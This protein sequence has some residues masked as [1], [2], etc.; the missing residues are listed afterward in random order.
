[1]CHTY[2]RSNV[3]CTRTYSYHH[4]LASN[5]V[6]VFFNCWQNNRFITWHISTR[7]RRLSKEADRKFVRLHQ[8]G[9]LR[10]RGGRYD[11]IHIT[12]VWISIYTHA[13]CLYILNVFACEGNSQCE[14]CVILNTNWDLLCRTV[15]IVHI[16]YDIW[17]EIPSFPSFSLCCFAHITF[18]CE[19]HWSTQ[20]PSLCHI[21]PLTFLGQSQMTLYLAPAIRMSH[22]LGWQIGM[23]GGIQGGWQP[24]LTY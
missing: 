1:M 13:A 11:I 6:I 24:H 15:D 14:L 5:F 7:E 17:K 4:I 2:K 19:L 22:W 23:R 12:Q 20:K 18:C 8:V 21:I 16:C 9:W 10:G 3:W